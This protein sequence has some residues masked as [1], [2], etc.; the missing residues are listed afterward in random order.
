MVQVV[1]AALVAVMSVFFAGVNSDSGSSSDAAS[2]S[3]TSDY[4]V[5]S[6]SGVGADPVAPNG[7]KDSA[8]VPEPATMLLL[9]SSLAGLAAW[10]KNKK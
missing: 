8:P 5:E 6:P 10:R 2:P 3:M 4:F 7:S 9:G 1:M